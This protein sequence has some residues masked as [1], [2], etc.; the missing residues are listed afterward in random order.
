MAKPLF[1]LGMSTLLVASAPGS[2]RA[3]EAGEWETVATGEVVVK[4]RTLPN[5]PIREVWAEGDLDAEVRDI[6][7]TLVEAPKFPGFMPYVKEARFLGS[8]DEDGGRFVYTRLEFPL[9][10]TSRDYVVKVY[11]DESVAADGTGTFR[12]HWKAV[13]DRLPKRPNT[14]RLVYNE[15]SWKVTPLA[16]GKSHVVYK[17]ITDPGGW[18]PAFAADMGNKTGVVDAF[19]AVEKEAKR[20]AG[21]RGS[22]PQTP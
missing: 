2:V 16:D 6:Q 1:L 19:R 21:A 5:S 20:R 4:S 22:G 13:A 10:I 17:F 8:A 18:I 7:D 12:N 11:V 15:G 14:V 9:A 3:A